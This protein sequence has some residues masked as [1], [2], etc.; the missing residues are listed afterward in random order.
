MKFCLKDFYNEL[1]PRLKG[2]TYEDL[3]EAS[4]S[5]SNVRIIV[6]KNTIILKSNNKKDDDIGAS[7]NNLIYSG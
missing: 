6:E 7:L 1:N 2:L 5:D 4:V 3:Y